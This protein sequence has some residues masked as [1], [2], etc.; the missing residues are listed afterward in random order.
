MKSIDLLQEYV[1][2]ATEAEQAQNK[3]K[4]QIGKL[5]F[6][7]VANDIR[8]EYCAEKKE[9]VFT[10]TP[11]LM[12]DKHLLSPSETKQFVDIINQLFGEDN[13]STDK[14]E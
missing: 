11:S 3:T 6:E 12:I 5:K 2:K 7:V 10:F 14:S 1:K 4:F 9:V 13:D 8:E